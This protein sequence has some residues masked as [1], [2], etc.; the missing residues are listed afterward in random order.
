MSGIPRSQR[1][2]SFRATTAGAFYYWYC[3]ANTVTLVKSAYFD[4][5]GTAAGTMNMFSRT[6]AGPSDVHILYATIDPNTTLAW[7][8]WCVLNPGEYLYCQPMAAGLGGH[9][10]G[11]ILLGPPPFPPATTLLPADE[12]HG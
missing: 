1:L 12:P 10:S 8:G 5:T 6:G 4:N 9:V 11:A 2:F 7:E 3:P